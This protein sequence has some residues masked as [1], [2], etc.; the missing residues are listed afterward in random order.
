MQNVVAIIIRDNLGRY[1]VHWRAASR[2]VYPG[3]AGL[4]AGGK[5]ELGESPESAALR[6]LRE[7]TGI[8]SSIRFLFSIEYYEPG[9]ERL[10]HIFELSY[11]GEIVWDRREWERIEWCDEQTV[12]EYAATGKLCPD[13]AIFFQKYLRHVTK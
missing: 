1:L 10:L 13:T 3:L 11:V 4:G 5:I 7:E 8:D 2:K 6:E 12:A 9:V